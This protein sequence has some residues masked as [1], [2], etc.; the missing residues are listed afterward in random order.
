M[1]LIRNIGRLIT[2]LEE[3]LLALLLGVMIILATS[4]I[5]MRNLW[6]SGVDWSDPLLRVLVLWLGLLGAMAATR[7]GSHIKIDL[8]SKLLPAAAARFLDPIT[9]LVSASICAIVC[10]HASRFVMMEYED[11]ISAFATVPA[12]LCE[13][14]IPIGFGLMALRFSASTVTGLFTPQQRG[15]E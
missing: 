3:S 8:L 10:Y 14:I 15:A 5:F 1:L 4:Q 7:D 13:I 11:G 12:W 9:N 6:E 2:Y